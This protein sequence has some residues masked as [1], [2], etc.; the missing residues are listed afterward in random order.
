[1]FAWAALCILLSTLAAKA[2]DIKNSGI[3][4]FWTDD[5]KV[6]DQIYGKT[7]DKELYGASLPSR[8]TYGL[9]LKK[10]ITI[11]ASD[12]NERYLSNGKSILEFDPHTFDM[13]DR[14]AKLFAKSL[15]SEKSKPSS[16]LQF[17]SFSDF[18]PISESTDPETYNYL[19]HLE[20]SNKEN[21]G[22]PKKLSNFKSYTDVDSEGETDEAYRSIQ[23]I[24]DAHEANKGT[25][26]NEDEDVPVRSKVKHYAPDDSD[27]LR[28]SKS[29]NRS[30]VRFLSGN[31]IKSRCVTGRCRTPSV[32]VSS[33]PYIRKI[34]HYRYS[35]R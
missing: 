18:K 16:A 1:M 35:R 8:V 27:R 29:R 13:S 6:F 2:A 3:S 9:D 33:R 28:Y 19:K 4:Q 26:S 17:I 12:K 32:R 14:Y 5:Y 10:P 20:H 25:E 23:D 7:S 34:K 22:I 24:L 15:Y 31:S 30:K 21:Y 11:D